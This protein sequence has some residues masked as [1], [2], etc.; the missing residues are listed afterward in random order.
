VN[1]S[2]TTTTR[3]L[4][5]GMRLLLL[6]FCVTVFGAGAQLFVLTEY[7]DR[8]FA[9]PINP[10]LTA[11]FI[12]AAYWSSLP[13]M[14]LSS[15]QHTWA[16]ARVAVPGVLLFTVLT[17]VAT[18]IHLDRFSMGS[19]FGWVWL[20]VYVIVPP[21]MIWLLVRQLRTPSQDPARRAPLPRWMQL[22]LVMQALVMLAVGAAL[23]IAPQAT[24]SLWPWML[25]PLTGQAVG[26][27]LIGVGAVAADMSWENDFERI[28]AALNFYAVFGV[29]QLIA[30]AR[31]SVDVDW[32]GVAIWAYLLFILS[33]LF[34]GL[35]GWR[36]ARLAIRWS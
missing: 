27:W 33:V 11:A 14:F 30:L 20:A 5:V 9:W 26:A 24:A 31:Y 1:N 34:V 3:P 10:P 13:F 17:L 22:V 23:F 36:D 32:R 8:F 7:T 2:S 19:I 28:H 6:V 25:T 29:L 21:V 12:G 16:R 18:L 4:I 15:R 35:K